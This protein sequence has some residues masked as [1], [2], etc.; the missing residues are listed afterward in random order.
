MLGESCMPV[1]L[2]EWVAARAD[3]AMAVP[4]LGIVGR[5]RRSEPGAGNRQRLRG[6][7]APAIETIAGYAMA[8]RAGGTFYKEISALS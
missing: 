1:Y 3:C 8:T 2:C 5:W 7:A 4:K 6:V